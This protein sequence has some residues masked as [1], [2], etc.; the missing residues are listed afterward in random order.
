MNSFV[1]LKYL[2]SR[3]GIFP[4]FIG[5]AFAHVFCREALQLI[6][7][8]AVLLINIFKFAWFKPIIRYFTLISVM[9]LS[10]LNKQM[11]LQ[12]KSGVTAEVTSREYESILTKTFG[13]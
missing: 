4:N 1:N 13:I 3:F 6:S 5:Y 11:N 9:R 7:W 2:N 10:T 8:N 12:V